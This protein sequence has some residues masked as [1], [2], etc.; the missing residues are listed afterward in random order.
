MGNNND[1]VK[2]R[3]L[4][5]LKYKRI[6]QTDFAKAF[7]VSQTYVGA[8]RKSIPVDKLKR[9]SELYPD[10]SRDWFL[11]GE[12]KMINYD[13]DKP[14]R[15]DDDENEVLLLPVSAYA[16]G[17]QM[18]SR[19]VSRYECQRIKSPVAGAEFA[20]PI[21]GDSMEPRFHEGS[22]LLV[23]RINDRAF[24]P[25]GH[26]MVVDTENGV[27]VKNLLPDPSS[28]EDDEDGYI[29]AESINP[30]YPPLGFRSR[31]SMRSTA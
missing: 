2:S 15:W 14:M 29:L 23:K 4:E 9:I 26:T 16:G 18:F 6:S 10:L 5:Y 11:F 28:A 22:T 1:T 19:G 3:L 17:L 31:L 8:I 25:W 20:I 21:S 24:I 12:G 27:L 7:G 30:K 13:S